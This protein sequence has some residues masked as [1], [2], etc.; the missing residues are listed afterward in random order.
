ML[1]V[2]RFG[3]GASAVALHGFSLTGAQF[4]A[5]PIG[6]FELIAPD[7]PGHGTSPIAPEDGDEALAIVADAINA[8]A[9]MAP[10]VGYSQGGRIALALT[11]LGL[12]EPTA[13]VLVSAT[14]GIED[15]DQRADRRRSDSELADRILR[16]G[17][18]A[19]VDA[20]TA[21]GLTSTERLPAEDRERDRAMRLL[22]T[23]EGLASAL[24][25]FGQG[26]MPSVWSA[27]KSIT[28]PTL[29][30][31]GR[32][33]AHYTTVGV[34]MASVIGSNAELVTISGAGHNPFNDQP[35]AT[36]AII[37]GFL[38]QVFSIGTGVP[39]DQS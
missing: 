14:A 18:R 27:L 31:T 21:G 19:F 17:V 13:L 7:L 38:R 26:A 16:H 11:A 22:N 4:A 2:R 23:E 39:E 9:P 37:G 24:V 6:P 35:A 15:P 25:A 29:V 32:T 8:S 12:V 1:S 5:I 10:I 3:S 33:D 30:V 36:A 20:W 34:R 28:V